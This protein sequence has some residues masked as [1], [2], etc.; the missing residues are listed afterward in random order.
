MTNLQQ[1][2]V[3]GELR[4]K[5][6]PTLNIVPVGG[7]LFRNLK[8][9]YKGHPDIVRLKLGVRTSY[10]VINPDLVE[11]VLVTKQR[12]FIKGKFLQRTKKV[13]GEGLLTS[14]GDFHHRE[15]RLVQ[16]AFHMDRIDSYAK[17][18]TDYA[19]SIMSNWS[20]NQVLDVHVEMTRLTM[21]IVAK[22]LFDVDVLSESKAIAKDLATTIEYFQRLTSPLSG[23]L[24]RLPSNR[25]YEEAVKR[26]DKMLYDLIE[27]KRQSGIDKGDLLSMLLQARDESGLQMTYELVRDEVL[28]VFAAGHETTDNAL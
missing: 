2:R 28:V 11:Q 15:R 5:Q 26:I 7:F 22:C 1:S 24:Q 27:S 21:A 10:L 12:D 9:I 19:T 17:I 23:L 18:M 4:G 14:E 6:I 20:D 16:P 25:K 8:N 13:F 3:R